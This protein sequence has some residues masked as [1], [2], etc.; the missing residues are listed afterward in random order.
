MKRLGIKIVVVLLVI[1][2]IFIPVN[3]FVKESWEYNNNRSILAFKEDP[4]PVD[5]LNL[6]TSHAMYGYSFKSLGVSHLDLALPSQPIAYDLKLL[7]AYDEHLKPGGVVIVS[8]SQITFS[9]SYV[10]RKEIYYRVLEREDIESASLFQYYTHE[11]FPALNSGSVYAAISREIRD[12]RFDAHKPWENGGLNYSER[13]FEEVTAQY[14]NAVNNHEIEENMA[15]LQDIIDY[16]KQQGYRVVLA[17]EPVHAS[18]HA[19]FDEGV[20]E[21]LVFQHVEKLDLDVPFLN[22]MGDERF[23]HE[24]SFFHNPDHLNGKGRKLLSS[25]VYEDLKRLGYIEGE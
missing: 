2:A 24:Q 7:Q 20:M 12:F 16:C 3:D 14:E 11:R 1:I 8:L 4:Q 15:H 23:I 19:Y 13:K 5:I 21:R 10:G 25:L 22:Y 6:G 17:M 18:Y 9:N